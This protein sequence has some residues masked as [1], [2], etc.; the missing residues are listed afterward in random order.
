MP[1]LVERLRRTAAPLCIV[2]G[3]LIALTSAIGRFVSDPRRLAETSNDPAAVING[4]VALIASLLLVFVLIALY[5]LERDDGRSVRVVAFI[6]ALAGTVLLAG[7]FWFEA[8]VVPYLA[9]VAPAALAGDPGGA[10]LLGAI[11][12]LTRFSGHRV[13]EGHAAR[14]SARRANL[15]S[16]VTGGML[17]IEV[18]RRCRL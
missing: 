17:P 12:G 16:K 4:V 18:C 15:A 13:S 7:D 9:D 5:D 1:E 2:T 11:V 14:P 3:A 6:V 10:L 8:F